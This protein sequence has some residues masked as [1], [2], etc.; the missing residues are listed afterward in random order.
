M[1]RHIEVRRITHEEWLAVVLW[2]VVLIGALYVWATQRA[3]LFKD[4][5]EYYG[6]LARDL[7]DPAHLPYTFRLL[8]PWLASL[9]PLETAEAFTVITLVSLLLT[10]VLLYAF[11]ARCGFQPA[12]SFGALTIFLCSSVVIRMLTT[13]TYVD[14][15]TYALTIATFLALIARRD[16]LFSLLVAVGSLNRETALL[17]LPSYLVAAWPM[18]GARGW[19][20][21]TLV[22][23]IPFTALVVL[24]LAKLAVLGMLGH[25]LLGMS[26]LA[27]T[28]YV[29]RIPR[30][31][32]LLDV[33][34]L[35]GLAWLALILGWRSAPRWL[36]IYGGLVI[37]QLLISRGDESRNLSHLFPMIIPLVALLLEQARARSRPVMAGLVICVVLSMIHFRW[38]AIP[39]EAVRYT[40]VALGTTAGGALIAWIWWRDRRDYREPGDEIAEAGARSGA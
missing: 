28:G 31:G 3:G 40:L 30:L 9:L 33:Y 5:T 1:A 25:G 17:L 35:F 32:D 26:S 6:R 20:R 8:T 4:D 14:P 15:L 18:R 16:V 11:M 34:S 10:A 27:Y 39:L 36:Q 19:L 7:A 24:V 12:A 2:S 29:Q 38:A 37:A 23:A 13:P 21:A 22:C